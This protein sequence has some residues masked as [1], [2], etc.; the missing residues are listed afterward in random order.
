MGPANSTQ[1]RKAAKASAQPPASYEILARLLG[2]ANQSTCPVQ[3]SGDEQQ[4][5]YQNLVTQTG[6]PLVPSAGTDAFVGV[7]SSSLVPGSTGG[8]QT[9]LGPPVDSL[10]L[11]NMEALLAPPNADGTPNPDYFKTFTPSDCKRKMSDGTIRC[12]YTGALPCIP[13]T[14]PFPVGDP[15]VDPVTKWT[16]QL[17]QCKPTMW[18]CNFQTGKCE[19]SP[20]GQYVLQ[21][22]C[23]DSCIMCS[24]RGFLVA[25]D[26]DGKPQCYR[27]PYTGIFNGMCDSNPYSICAEHNNC[28][29]NAAACGDLWNSQC[30][31]TSHHTHTYC[32]DT[33]PT[34]EGAYQCTAGGYV[35]CTT[36][37]GCAPP[38]IEVKT[39]TP[40]CKLPAGARFAYQPQT[41]QL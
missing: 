33:V 41:N 3:K 27:S 31:S 35:K 11:T 16:V 20:T 2:A 21:K 7:L 13:G 19:Q 32:I 30:N 29:T 12:P 8:N 5:C 4:Y 15:M 9:Y 25:P 17:Y 14:Q 37:G 22:D 34:P 28:S 36:P 39:A 38:T 26:K 24:F 1:K 10:G 40:A 6:K 23:E 18:G